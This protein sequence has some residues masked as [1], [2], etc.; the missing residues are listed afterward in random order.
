MELTKSSLITEIP[1]DSGV[2][3][4][5]TSSELSDAK[6]LVLVIQGDRRVFK[7]DLLTV[8]SCGSWGGGEGRG[9][10]RLSLGS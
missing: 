3:S 9:G 6:V 5:D 1:H 10:G 8:V 2:P 4:Q 7:I